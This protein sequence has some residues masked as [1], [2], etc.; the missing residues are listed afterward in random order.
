[1]TYSGH[2]IKIISILIFKKLQLSALC[3]PRTSF[4]YSLLDSFFGAVKTD[5]DVEILGQQ[6]VVLPVFHYWYIIVHPHKKSKNSSDASE[7]WAFE[8]WQNKIWIEEFFWEWKKKFANQ[9]FWTKSKI[10]IM[11]QNNI[12]LN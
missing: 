1:M 8:S 6:E 4:T 10:K 5:N 11:F 7:S 3:Y 12:V 9:N 2:M